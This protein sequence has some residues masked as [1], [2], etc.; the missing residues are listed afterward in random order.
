MKN[1]SEEKTRLN[2][3]GTEEETINTVVFI[4]GILATIGALI[5]VVGFCD[6]GAKDWIACIIGPVY[7]VIRI[8]EKKIQGFKNYAKYAYMTTPFWVTIILVVSDDGKFAAVTQ[9]YFMYL[10]LSV[11]YYD[12]KVVF[13]CAGI[14]VA[15]TI[16]AF[17]FFTE[18]MLKLDEPTVWLYIFSIYAMTTVLAAFI[19]SRMRKLLERTRQI[20]AYEDEL[21]YLEQ[22]EQKEEKQRE[23]IHNINH[24]FMAIGELA[25]VENCGRIV[26]LV[27]ELNGNLLSNERIIYTAHKVLNAILSEK[28]N[29]ATKMNVEFEVYV[30]PVLKINAITDGDLVSMVGNLLDNALEASVRCEGEKRKIFMWIYMEKEGRICVMKIINNFVNTPVVQ[31]SRFLTTKKN[32][33][34]HGIGIK[35]VEKTAEKYGGYLQCM[36]NEDK[37]TSLLILPDSKS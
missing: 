24:Y 15:S 19:A 17:I 32:K 22:L 9:G 4:T 31:K 30:E 11:A 37:F 12:V 5:V 1:T 2:F 28:S 20:R 34:M 6:G 26:S 25:R 14:T 36:V 7:T 16:G 35:S 8:L 23:F 27:E 10:M 18:A 3:I 21:V 29:E 13:W 33:E